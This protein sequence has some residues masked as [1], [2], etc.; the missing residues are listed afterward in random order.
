MQASW[1]PVEVEGMSQSLPSVF[2]EKFKV[3]VLYIYI[4]ILELGIVLFPVP[5]WAHIFKLISIIIIIII[6]IIIHPSYNN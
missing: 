4:Y 1:A 6:I 2:G 5:Y 3:G